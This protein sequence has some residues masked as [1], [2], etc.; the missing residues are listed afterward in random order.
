MTGLHRKI[1]KLTEKAILDYGMIHSGDRVLVC[2]SGGLDSMGLLKILTG[3]LVQV[4]YPFA[5]TAAY[6]DL[7]FEESEAKRSKQ[8][9]DHF[10]SLDVQFEIAPTNIAKLAFAPNARKNPCFICAHHRRRTIYEIARRTGCTKIAYGHHKDDIIETLLINVLYGREI[11]SMNPMQP[12]FGG[13]RHII[14]P[15]AYVDEFL[16]KRFGRESGLPALKNP[17][18]AEGQTRRQRI[19][20]LIARLQSEEKYANI[21]ENIFKA[22]YHVK[23]DF[24]PKESGSGKI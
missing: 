16:I 23:V 2:V 9:E 10:K 7:G 20:D 14:R 21:R 18:P 24:L 12:V 4:H 6:I 22:H 5:M 19:K 11:S 15:F 8:L 1:R 17:C 3:G 13:S